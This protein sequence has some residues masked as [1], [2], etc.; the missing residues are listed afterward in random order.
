MN[1]HSR[2]VPLRGGVEISEL[3]LGTAPLG[4]LYTSV[5][6]CESRAVISAA[7]DAGI[8]Y[9]DCAPHYGKGTAERRLGVA[10]QKI[11]KEKFV[12]STKVGRLLV[13]GDGLA[14]TDFADAP[15]DLVRVFDFSASGIERSLEESLTR[16]GLN[17]VEMVLIHDPDDY[18]D[19]AIN[20]AMPTLIRMR[21]EGVIKAIGIGMNQSAMPTR[22]VNETDVDFVLIAGRYTLLDQSAEF[23]L[24]PAALSRGVDVIAAGVFSSGILANPVAGAYFDYAPAS[25]PAIAHAQELKRLLEELGVKLEQAAIQFPMR[26]PA[27]KAVVIGCRSVAEVSK[28]IE[29][30]DADI[31]TSTWKAVSEFIESSGGWRD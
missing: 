21:D 25:K 23:D 16:L 15:P 30:F 2:R 26:H 10:L 3:G 31:P 19:Q 22:F 5:S 12:I 13:P 28:N 14:D 27:V 4:G 24:L 17:Q 29:A 1:L 6:E 8:R 9:F 20:E 7:L 11:S 18:A